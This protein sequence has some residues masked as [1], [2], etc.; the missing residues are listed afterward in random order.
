MN[1]REFSIA[2]EHRLGTRYLL[3]NRAAK[4]PADLFQSTG[5]HDQLLMSVLKSI[6]KSNRC[7][8]IKAL[9]QGDKTLA[10]IAPF[11]SKLRDDPRSDIDVVR[12]VDDLFNAAQGLFAKRISRGRAGAIEPE[13]IVKLGAVIEFPGCGLRRH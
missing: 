2:L 8:H 6:Y 3:V 1:Y 10:A 7:Y 13:R 11:Q 12:L 5:V 4:E 9:I